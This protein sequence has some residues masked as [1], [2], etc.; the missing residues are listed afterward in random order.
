VQDEE[1]AEEKKNETIVVKM[2]PIVKVKNAP[3]NHDVSVALLASLP[4]KANE[5]VDVV[6]ILG[7]K[8]NVEDGIPEVPLEPANHNMDQE[9]IFGGNDDEEEEEEE[10]ES[11]FGYKLKIPVHAR[12]MLCG[13]EMDE[14]ITFQKHFLQWRCWLCFPGR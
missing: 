7:K 13:I 12:C 10:K 6:S 4:L 9:L 3:E 11:E 5:S 14:S 1:V 2:E 8:E